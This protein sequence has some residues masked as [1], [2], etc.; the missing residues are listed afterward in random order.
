MANKNLAGQAPT[1]ESSD[2]SQR[3]PELDGNEIV[4]PTNPASAAKLY[5]FH[6]AAAEQQNT[7][8][9]QDLEEVLR[10][11]GKLPGQQDQ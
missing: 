2:A 7:E 4:D 1:F 5:R 10:G 11:Y 9:E 3:T 8:A 6:S